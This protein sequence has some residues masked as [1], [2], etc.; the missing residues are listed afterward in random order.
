MNKKKIII[1]ILIGLIVAGISFTTGY[2]IGKEEPKQEIKGS[3]TKEEKEQGKNNETE[4]ENNKKEPT[5]EDNILDE[6]EITIT[7]TEE[8][9]TTTN[10]KNVIIAEN[11]R[12]IP[13]IIYPS[14]QNVADK[15]E[16]SLIQLSDKE[17]DDIISTS[18]EIAEVGPFAESTE[19]EG[20]GASLTFSN[21][22]IY[23]KRITFNLILEGG[24]GGVGWFNCYGY[25]YDIT[26]GE[27]LTFE[28]I[29]ND[30]T[31][32]MTD[33]MPEVNRKLDIIKKETEIYE[34]SE[35]R[36]KTL[37]TTNGNWYFTA[38]GLLI[39]F[40]KYEIA[41]GATGPVAIEI[42]KDFINPYLKDEYKL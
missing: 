19:T 3:S 24:F 20:L 13:E 38:T 27:L 32:L 28:S 37:I 16:K 7:Y 39:V 23:N 26:T 35:E 42:S 29:T 21:L 36:L 8:S 18:K 6:D 22:P 4:K 25:N 12:N 15:I 14:N 10:K 2:L 33:L 41:D 30:Y 31:K 5:N 9:S 1:S 11:N 40:Q 34:T 17:W